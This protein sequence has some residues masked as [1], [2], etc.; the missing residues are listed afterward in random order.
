MILVTKK[1]IY[2]LKKKK[3]TNINYRLSIED[4]QC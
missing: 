4:K 2:S 3:N 1:Y